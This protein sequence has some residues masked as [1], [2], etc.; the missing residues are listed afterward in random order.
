MRRIHVVDLMLLTT[1]VL[2]ALN[3]TVTKYVL[4]HGFRPLAYSGVRYG[5]AALLFAGITFLRERSLAIRLRDMPLLIAPAVA[6]LLLNQFGYVYSIDYTTASTV[7]LIL[8]AT[9]IFVALFALAIGL[10]QLPRAF[11]L[12]AAASFAGVALVAV[13]GEGGLSGDLKGDALAVMTAATWAGYSIAIAPLMRRYSPYRISAVV[14][15]FTWVGLLIAAAP[16]LAKQDF[17]LGWI[18][19]LCFAYAVVG[20][21]LTTNVLWFTAIDRV[22][23]SRASLFANIQPFFGAIFAVLILSEHL[24]A[25][26]VVGGFAI[27]AGIVLERRAHVPEVAA[28]GAE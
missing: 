23:P 3:F 16:Q 13:G 22:G 10:E 8:G 28:A 5:V 4:T 27:A 26:Q 1:V 6:F 18:V 14:L 7:A 12:G 15:L 20:P 25:I 19:W 17:H 24:T 21:L 11:W 9:P 2:W